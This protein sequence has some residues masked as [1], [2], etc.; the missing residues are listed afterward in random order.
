[1]RQRGIL[2]QDQL[3]RQAARWLRELERDVAELIDD[4]RP[5]RRGGRVTRQGRGAASVET[6][7]LHAKVARGELLGKPKGDAEIVRDPDLAILTA[8]VR[9]VTNRNGLT[10]RKP[11][12]RRKA[13]IRPRWCRTCGRMLDTCQ[14]IGEC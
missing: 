14:T 7:R 8:R 3:D 4:M 13:R 11:L 10:R 9:T 12:T 5:I 1:M 2:T 6:L